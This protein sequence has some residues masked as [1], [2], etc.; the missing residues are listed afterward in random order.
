MERF[1]RD[2]YDHFQENDAL[3]VTFS[4]T[5]SILE[6]PIHAILPDGLGSTSSVAQ[7]P[8]KQ[9]HCNTACS[10][11]SLILVTTGLNAGFLGI[12]PPLR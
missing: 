1:G 8:A 11:F 6:A 2:F 7:P 3:G 5:S 10:G 12:R 9:L 4:K